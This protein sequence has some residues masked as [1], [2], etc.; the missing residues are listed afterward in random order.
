MLARIGIAVVASLLLL[1]HL[2]RG[3]LCGEP[4]A[5]V[6]ILGAGLA[7]IT[8]A[9]TLHENG[10]TNFVIL[11]AR[12][13]I[14]GRMRSAE[15][16]GVRVEL[17][18]NWIQKIDSRNRN[19]NPIWALSQRCTSGGLAGIFS[20]SDDLAVYSGEVPGDDVTDMLDPPFDAYDDAADLENVLMRMNNRLPDISVREGLRSYGWTPQT[21]AEDLVEWFNFDFC[22]A[23]SPNVSSYYGL[24]TQV[25]SDYREEFFV[26]DQRGFSYLVQCLANDFLTSSQDQ[27]LHLNA[28]ITRI[29]WS[30]D[31]VCAT[32]SEGGQNRRYCAP[33]AILTFSIGVLQSEM[34][35]AQFVPELPSWKVDVINRFSMAHYLKIFVEFNE[36]FWDE[37]E[38]FGR[39]SNRRGYYILFQALQQFLPNRPNLTLATLVEE[40]ADD[41]VRQPLELTK[42]QLV[43]ALTSIYGSN[44]SDN[45]VDIIVPDWDINPLYLGAYTNVP[46]GVTDETHQMLAN[47][48]GKLYFSGEAASQNNSGFL[49]GAYYA[50]IDSANSVLEARMT[51]SG[52]QMAGGN[53]TLITFVF[54]LTTR[55]TLG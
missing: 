50:G 46:V 32:A 26:T 28:T 47:P 33:Y 54:L 14:G 45:I 30:D 41:V 23:E 44:A 17:G 39:L 25:P 43:E 52:C 36:T 6:L 37:V 51:R 49:Q 13:E 48:V 5:D 12:E 29:E 4:D 3:Q 21:T 35:N 10:L 55:Y 16:A 19:S 27:R 2:A 18:A 9:K 1:A 11:E 53:W 7:G 15:I 8:A 24:T 20:D 42:A 31:C 34:R 38:Y 40:I 22:F